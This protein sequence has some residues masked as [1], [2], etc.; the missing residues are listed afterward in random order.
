MKGTIIMFLLVQEGFGNMEII[1]IKAN[2][3]RVFNHQYCACIG[4]FDGVHKGHQKLIETTIK[5]A[6]QTQMIPACICFDQD[7]WVVLNKC[8]DCAHL[9]PLPQRLKLLEHYGIKT[10]FVLHFDMD[11]AKMKIA[12]FISLLNQM[13]VKHLICGKDFSFG[14]CGKGKIK[15]LENQ[16]FSLNIVPEE[17]YQGS[18]ISS[19]TLEKQLQNGFI[20]LVNEQLG[21]IYCV[22]GV[23]VHGNQIGKKT[24]G[25]ATANLKMSDD[26]IIPKKG[27]YQGMVNVNGQM[28]NAM[29]NIGYNPTLNLREHLS[30][31]AHLLQFDQ[32]IYGKNAV[33]YFVDFLREEKN[34]IQK[35]N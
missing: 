19:S 34:L 29:I 17:C 10:C 12:T 22:E 1:K 15:D 26:Y 28:Y 18:K 27:V 5:K 6:K 21:R 20:K 7:P 24:L 33:F 30:I 13:N 8:E 3:T 32:D 9:T 2:E 23:I 31:E 4:Y 25:V 11:M 14:D 16:S 35:K